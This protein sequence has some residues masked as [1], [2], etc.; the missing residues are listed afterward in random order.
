MT[1]ATPCELGFKEI[2]IASD[3]S[4]TSENATNF[5]KGIA[6][7]FGSHILLAHVSEAVVPVAVPEG[8]W[9]EDNSAALI[10]KQLEE[11]RIALREEGFSAD[12]IDSYGSVKHEVEA[13]AR[14]HHADLVV[15]GTHSR[16]GLE[17]LLF[18]SEAECVLRSLTCPVLTVGPRAGMAPDGVWAPKHILCAIGLPIHSVGIAALAYKLAHSTG[19]SLTLLSVEGEHPD[20]TQVLWDRF[21]RDL[22]ALLPDAKIAKQQIRHFDGAK[23]SGKDIADIAWQLKADLI[24]MGATSSGALSSHLKRGIVP[25]VLAEAPCPVMTLNCR[26]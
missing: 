23:H 9:F 25:E 15:L 2:L 19:A 20:P 24:V 1:T 4:D 11:T 21:D 26:S 8:E 6:R 5:A 22:A 18:G 16:K 10:E 12:T 3:L 7:R 13:L 17:R 14:S